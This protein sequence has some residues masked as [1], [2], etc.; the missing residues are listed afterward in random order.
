MRSPSPV[1]LRVSEK[2]ADVLVV[3]LEHRDEHLVL[4]VGRALADHLAQFTDVI[5]LIHRLN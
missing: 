2:V 4:V 5:S 1:F 3:Y